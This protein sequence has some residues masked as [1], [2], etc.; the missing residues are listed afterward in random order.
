MVDIGQ[1]DEFITDP[2]HFMNVLNGSNRLALGY[3]YATDGCSKRAAQYICFGNSP[4]G[5][6]PITIGDVHFYPGSKNDFHG[7]LDRQRDDRSRIRAKEGAAAAE[8]YGPDLERHEAV[9]SR[10]WA[11]YPDAALF[12]ADYAGP[13][14]L[15]S[16]LTKGNASDGNRFE[17]EANLWWG[18]YETWEE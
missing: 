17:K 8:K 16:W 15:R 18:G 2:F 1:P 3:A 4:A 13:E 5:G 7:K 11:R 9:H 14:S 10:Q 12:I 6:K